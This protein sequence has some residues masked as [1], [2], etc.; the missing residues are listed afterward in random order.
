MCLHFSQHDDTVFFVFFIFFTDLSNTLHHIS[1]FYIMYILHLTRKDCGVSC[2][3]T[4]FLKNL[5]IRTENPAGLTFGKYVS[6]C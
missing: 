6:F 5:K 3:K 1:H 2:Q 4:G